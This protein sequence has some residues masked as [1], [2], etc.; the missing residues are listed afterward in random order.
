MSKILEEQM[1]DKAVHQ[2]WGF[3]VPIDEAV[4]LA[5]IYALEQQIELLK[6]FNIIDTK[7]LTV[8]LW[9]ITDERQKLEEQLKLL[10]DGRE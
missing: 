7:S 10:K 5:Q 6:K 4:K 1:L 8:D 2:P 9:R 3:M